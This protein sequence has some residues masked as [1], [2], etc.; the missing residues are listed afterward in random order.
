MKDLL[1]LCWP[2]RSPVSYIKLNNRSQGVGG[3]ALR[4][5]GARTALITHPALPKI[6]ALVLIPA[7]TNSL[8]SK[9]RMTADAC[10]RTYRPVRGSFTI[11]E[12]LDDDVVGC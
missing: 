1:G 6:T 9:A 3:F 10:M 11:R 8:H 5:S 4:A 2:G 7:K 12:S